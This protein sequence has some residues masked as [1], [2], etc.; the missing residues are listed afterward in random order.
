MLRCGRKSTHRIL[1]VRSESELG[2]AISWWGR[3]LP[4]TVLV[5]MG[6]LLLARRPVVVCGH[7]HACA[8]RR[9]HK[10]SLRSPANSAHTA[11]GTQ[12][13]WPAL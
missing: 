8:R 4:A 5:I 11:T 1:F 6:A 9:W 3:V 2:L 10:R 7:R 12:E 13:G